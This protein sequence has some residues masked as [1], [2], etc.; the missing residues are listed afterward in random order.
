MIDKVIEIVRESS[1]LLMDRNFSVQSKGSASNNVTSVDLSVQKFLRTHLGTL[2]DNCGFIGEESEEKDYEKPY[3]WIVDPIDGTANFIRNIGF[4]GISVGLIKDGTP[5]LGVVYN[6]YRDEMFYAE[7]GKG[8]F[9]NG[10]RIKVSDNNLEHSI[11][12]TA[13]SLYNKSL[14]KPCLN[15]IEEVYKEC[16]DIRRMGSAALELVSLAC[17]RVEL[18]FEIRVFP[19]DFAASEVIISE[20]GGYVGTI[21]F[22]KTVFHRPIPLICA[23]TKEN[24]EYLKQVVLNEI[25]KIPYTD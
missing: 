12:C 13:M 4:S 11:F 18:Y 23:N 21:E 17:G 22:D 24:Y 8:A 5:V 7:K 10:E 14:A 2:M 16:E 25:P 6:P 19:W 15:I 9:L 1:H 20:A 3:L